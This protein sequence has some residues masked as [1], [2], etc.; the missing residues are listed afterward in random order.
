MILYQPFYSDNN[1]LNLIPTDQPSENWQYMN[2]AQRWWVQ[3][4]G[5]QV[6]SFTL[7][8]TENMA[9]RWQNLRMYMRDRSNFQDYSGT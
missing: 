1:G 5:A 2:S 8:H 3:A 9:E 6:A 7:H 4:D